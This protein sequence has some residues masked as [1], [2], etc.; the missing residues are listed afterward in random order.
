[1]K[2]RKF[3]TLIELLVVIAIIAILAG[4]LLPAL[5]MA[6]AKGRNTYC[7]NNQKQSGVFFTMYSDDWN[8]IFPPVHGGVLSASGP[9]PE[10][11]GAAAVAWFHYLENYGM[12]TKYLRCPEDPAVHSGFDDNWD[13]RQ[14]YIYNGMCAFNSH[15]NRVMKMS[16]YIVLSE[17][18]G[19]KNSSAQDTTALNHQ[20][21]P[22]FS[23]PSDWE[24]MLAKDRHGKN[25]SNYLFFDGHARG[26][27]FAETVNDR[28]LDKN[29]HF[30]KEWL[31]TVTGYIKDDD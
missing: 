11:T 3:F 8:S 28:T 20:G 10:R 24:G 15:A 19:D 30:V 23:D 16:Q 5:S 1:M 12:V 22:G 9:H 21:Y 27:S 6:R 25:R 26:M 29:H 4:M 31:P 13:K 14:S 2:T 7:L 17:R 18:G